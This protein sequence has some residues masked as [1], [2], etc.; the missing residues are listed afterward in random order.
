M[1]FDVMRVQVLVLSKLRATCLAHS[2]RLIEAT[3]LMMANKPEKQLK[4]IIL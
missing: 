3:H 1:I 2:L 4:A